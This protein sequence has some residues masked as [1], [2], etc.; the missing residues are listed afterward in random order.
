MEKY[1]FLSRWQIKVIQ[2]SL[3]KREVSM[4]MQSFS[5]GCFF[6]GMGP[7]ILNQCKN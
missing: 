7:K 6:K 4:K 5:K 2:L 1:Y 3:V